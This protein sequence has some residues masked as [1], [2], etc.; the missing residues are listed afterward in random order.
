MK[1]W[2]DDERVE[3][4]EACSEAWHVSDRQSDRND[5]MVEIITDAVQAQR[6]WAVDIRDDALRSGLA[7]KLKQWKR[8]QAKGEVTVAYNGEVLNTA[9]L[10]GTKHRDDSG[11]TYHEQTLFDTMPWDEL[12][13]KR[14]EDLRQRQVYDIRI[15]T[16]DRLLAL[17][18]LAPGASTPA[19][20]VAQLGTTI[21]SYLGEEVA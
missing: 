18:E 10:V 15:N 9:R 7:A 8:K 2:D 6:Q 1:H 16:W 5:R 14:R 4:D 19:E 20:A 17:E 12:K 11:D 3:Y 21:E 13:E